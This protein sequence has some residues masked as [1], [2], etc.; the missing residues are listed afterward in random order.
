MLVS[1]VAARVAMPWANFVWATILAPAS[2]SADA[3]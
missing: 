1:Y 3:P 2:V